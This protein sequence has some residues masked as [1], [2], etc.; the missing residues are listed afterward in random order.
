[1]SLCHGNLLA[2]RH[3]PGL[4]SSDG[5]DRGQFQSSHLS[6]KDR[7]KIFRG[8]GLFHAE[9]KGL[10]PAQSRLALVS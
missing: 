2:L 9:D 4:Q 10:P 8:I 5:G 7:M 6:D 3:I 1:M